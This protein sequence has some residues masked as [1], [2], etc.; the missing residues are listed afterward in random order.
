MRNTA[1]RSR[2]G[3]GTEWVAIQ[4]AR[5]AC[6]ASRDAP[7]RARWPIVTAVFL[8]A[9]VLGLAGAASASAAAGVGLVGTQLIYVEEGGEGSANLTIT[10]VG[11]THEFADPG[12]ALIALAPCTNPLGNVNL[13]RCT[14]AG[15]TDLAVGFA[16]GDDRVTVSTPLP[17]FLCGGTGADHLT[18]GPGDDVM[19]GGPGAD[20]LSGG[21]GV[22]DLVASYASDCSPQVPGEGD[23]VPNTLDGGVGIDFL[24]GG[25]GDDTMLGGAADDFVFGFGGVD[26][27]S[28]GE[29]ADELVGLDGADELT[30][31]PGDDDLSGGAGN[32]RLLGE[33]GNDELGGIVLMEVEGN[34]FASVDVG[35]DDMDG[36]PGNDGLAGGPV[37]PT[38]T[39]VFGYRAQA[40]PPVLETAEPNGSDTLRGGAG[41]DRVTY[42]MRLGPI[43]VTL[44]GVRNDGGPGELDLVE[45][46][47]E[48]LTGG[49]G[50]TRL[51]G[52]ANDNA[53]EGGRGPDVLLGG[54]GNDRVDGGPLDEAVDTLHG[55]EGIDAL[56]GGPGDD[57]LE[58]SGGNDQ[59]SGSGGSDLVDG[60]VDD[61]V[62]NGGAGDDRLL[63]GAGA[64]TL[65]GDAGADTADYGTAQLPVTAILDELR[66]DGTDGRDLIVEAE[67]L[68]GGAAGD[69]LRGDASA[70]AIDGGAGGDRIDGGPSVDALRGGPGRDVVRARDGGRDRVACGADTDFAPVDSLDALAP[71]SLERCERAD[72]GTAR[73]PRLLRFGLLNPQAC[74]LAVRFPKTNWFVPVQ[75]DIKLPFGSRVRS[76]G[77]VGRLTA[78]GKP[79]GRPRVSLARFSGGTVVVRQRRARRPFTVL[80]L[81]S[82]DFG[83]C[84][85]PAARR[86]AVRGADLM[87]RGMFRLRGR[88]SETRTRRAT[89]TLS[90]RCDGTLTQVARGTARVR[91]RHGGQRVTLSRGERHLARPVS[92]R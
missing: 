10:S 45:A 78:A 37:V 26:R 28:G 27:I 25:P 12:T 70:N 34:E 51:I 36:G 7:R 52:D 76:D 49:P 62:M 56:D 38:G 75:D 47:V 6:R 80:G 67:G 55:G 48:M 65:D 60:G 5:S 40:P 61:D 58:G 8:T 16:D 11:D 44:D 32:D 20:A 87:L 4:S 71:G 21:S 84:N 63:D 17:T 30:G 19:I 2:T 24:Y 91:N 59:L 72:D 39:R 79:H 64:D 85:R 15:V 23:V 88:Y 81:V 41:R 9:G 29:G 69:V 22:D 68:R 31:G 77:C 42:E 18:G 53:L 92:K 3:T 33:D 54:D 86:H 74:T 83:V 43:D 13:V 82:G 73:R 35:D 50:A 1:R 89:I 14:V 46:D 66:N 57:R 90:D